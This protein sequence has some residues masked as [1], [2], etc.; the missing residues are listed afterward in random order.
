MLTL[1]EFMKGIKSDLKRG[2]HEQGRGDG[3]PTNLLGLISN[4]ISSNAISL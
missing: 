3:T 1:M 4:V 2:L